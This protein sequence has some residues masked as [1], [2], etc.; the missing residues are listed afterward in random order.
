[1]QKN[2]LIALV[3]LV[4]SLFIF[5]MLFTKSDKNK[6]FILFVIL[7]LPFL[8]IDI[9]P[10]FGNLTTFE[11][12]IFVFYLYHVLIICEMGFLVNR[13]ENPLRGSKSST[14]VN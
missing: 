8:S 5:Q 13:K 9:F 2:Y 7:T 12:L 14:F 11:C 4:F 6:V 1:M 10:A 3:L